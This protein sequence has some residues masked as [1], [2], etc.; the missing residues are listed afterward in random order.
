MKK[1]IPIVEPVQIL[2]NTNVEPA[3]NTFSVEFYKPGTFIGQ[4]NPPTYVTVKVRALT[5]EGA[6]LIAKKVYPSAS[7][8]K[9][10]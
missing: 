3:V 10:V 8:F 2:S 9:I 7:D 4:Y 6:V 1:I 5:Q